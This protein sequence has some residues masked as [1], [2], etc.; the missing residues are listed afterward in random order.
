MEQNGALV[1]ITR[2][3]MRRI[4]VE[5]R[6]L[7]S[8]V[9]MAIATT[10]NALIACAIRHNASDI[11]LEPLEEGLRVRIRVD[12]TLS[13]LTT[14]QK[15]IEAQIVSRIKVMSKMRM[16][17]QRLPQDGRISVTYR[18]EP[19]SRMYNLR[20]SVIPHQLMS[21]PAE[22]AVLRLLGSSIAV[23]IDTLGFSPNVRTNM[24]TIMAQPQGMFLL[25]GP[26]GSGKTTTLNAM[27]T[28]MNKMS[29]NVITI[30]D[31]I[32][33]HIPGITQVQT[34]EAIGLT[35]ASALRAFLRQD[36]DII[37]VGEMRDMETAQIAVR[38][39]LTGHLVLS[40]LHTNDAPSAIPRLLDLGAEPYLVA[41]A[42]T[43]VMAQRLVKTLCTDCRQPIDATYAE[44]LP[45]GITPKDPNQPLRL[46]R[47]VGCQN[48]LGTGF[49]GR[50]GIYE[51][52]MVTSE[53]RELI[54]RGT[55]TPLSE[56]RRLAKETG[57]RQLRD[58]GVDLVLKGVT[59]VDDVRRVVFT[60]DSG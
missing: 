8:D 31:P 13:H 53:M 25:T 29:V 23:D 6:D 4:T 26:T 5:D 12:G 22:K 41:S 52:M 11:H 47:P 18:D 16:D 43:G 39:A 57:M 10:V 20:V 34:H 40:T 9:D 56:I 54:R 60:A 38:A 50:H 1:E 49:R 2:D 59:T 45:L 7:K 19:V 33:Y 24:D 48:C 14:L 42:L 28:R 30:E 36:P 44:L 35:F 21:R 15:D 3:D 58:E 27:L 32:E 51:M 55:G 17:D 46:Y 37:M